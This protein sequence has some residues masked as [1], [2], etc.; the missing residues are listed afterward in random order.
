LPVRYAR[1]S[2]GVSIAFWSQGG[3]YPL[4]HSTGAPF[5][6]VQ[7]EWSLP[8]YAMWFRAYGERFLHVRF[9]AR[10]S[11]LSSSDVTDFAVEAQSR[12]IEAVVQRLGIARFAL[13]ATQ[14]T[15]MAAVDL[16]VNRPD[17]VSHLVLIDG[18]TN[19]REYLRLPQ[20]VALRA[21]MEADWTLFTE[22]LA[23]VMSGDWS[24][25]RG[26]ENA[27]F[28]REC[29]SQQNCL[30][31]F[32]AVAGSDVSALLPRITQPTLV[33]H[34]KRISYPSLENARALVSGI[35]NARLVLLEG[36]WQDPGNDIGVTMR[37]IETLL[38]VQSVRAVDPD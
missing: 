38:G 6:H 2:D 15:T 37:A 5:N 27:R 20:T 7:L 35:P 3:G 24:A 23:N 8:D 11:G 9:D 28:F 10:G 33:L 36:T 12:D 34:H 25:E 18:Y 13:Q 32:D 17:L 29:V 31:F 1:T 22:S 26:A 30:A 16:A 4:V 14:A 21:L 19:G